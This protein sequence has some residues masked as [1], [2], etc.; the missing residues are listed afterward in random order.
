MAC[1]RLFVWRGECAKVLKNV[2]FVS[3]DCTE[4]FKLVVK[5]YQFLLPIGN[6]CPSSA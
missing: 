1:G 6:F 5:H 2:H 3:I 4:V